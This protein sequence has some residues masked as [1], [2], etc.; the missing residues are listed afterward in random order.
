[1]SDTKSRWRATVETLG[2]MK[3]GVA[4]IVAVAVAAAIGTVILQASP[5]VDAKELRRHY[6]AITD[7]LIWIGLTD[8]FHSAWFAV[9]LGLLA[10]NILAATVAH[11]ALRLD[12]IGM[13][14]AH[15]GILVA[16]AGGLA[17][18][19]LG[20]KG[21]V[22][23]AEGD[24][25]DRYVSRRNARDRL[26]PFTLHLNRFIVERY[27]ARLLVVGPKERVLAATPREGLEL[28][29]DWTTARVTVERVIPQAEPVVE[30]REDENAPVN[31]AARLRIE[32]NEGTTEF[33]RFARRESPADTL[34]Q[35]NG[36][37]AVAFD[38]ELTAHTNDRPFE[39]RAYAINRETGRA[40]EIPCKPGQSFSL[41]NAD[42]PAWGEVVA[43]LQENDNSSLGALLRIRV[44]DDNDALRHAFAGLPRFNPDVARQR[45]IALPEMD[46]VY[47]RPKLVMRLLRMDG[48]AEGIPFPPLFDLAWWPRERNGEV[49]LGS[50]ALEPGET[51]SVW[52][53]KLTLLEALQRATVDSRWVPSHER[54][55]IEAA[56]VRVDWPGGPPR[57][58]WLAT[59]MSGRAV[60]VGAALVLALSPSD[61]VREFR[62]DVALGDNDSGDTPVIRVNDPAGF[63]GW[64]IFLESPP[65]A[66][67]PAATFL[68]S[69]DP[70]LP[71]VYAGFALLA[72][73]TFVACFV[74][75]KETN[76]SADM[77]VQG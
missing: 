49:E 29:P 23:V 53:V 5:D 61:H 74:K 72:V 24:T 32:T 33:W 65:S 25:A 47:Y 50:Q 41:P 70:G 27:P 31:P 14:L 37:I 15:A 55:D 44:M 68:V 10:L 69:R 11:F 34:L 6:G 7:A 16:L 3:L 54:T 73:G 1:M 64:Q 75:G 46:F 77:R 51:V 28:A 13:L 21:I 59:T 39:P 48:E 19:L 38:N 36:R 45:P 62:A 2:A 52:D 17:W 12:R 76:T 63:R 66:M 4:L 35:S 67:D 58:Y 40:V 30:V 9:L 20:D 26:L 71:L 60:R 42:S 18:S 57:R 8:V 22:A 43:V 56:L